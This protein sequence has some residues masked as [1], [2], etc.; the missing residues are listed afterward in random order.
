[1]LQISHLLC[2]A[3]TCSPS[4]SPALRYAVHLACSLGATLHLVP[5]G[6]PDRGAWTEALRAAAPDDGAALDLQIEAPIDDPDAPVPDLRAYEQAHDVDLVVTGTPAD[7]GSTSPGADPP[8]QALL[9]GLTSSVLVVGEHAPTPPRRILVPTDLSEAARYA[10]DYATT[11]AVPSDAPIDLLHVIE[12]VPYVA[13]TRMDRL[14]LSGPSFPERR[15]RRHL[16]AFLDTLPDA[17]SSITPHFEFGDPADQIVR[18]ANR[19]EVDLVVLSAR[20]GSAPS[21]S[22]LGPV[23]ERVLRRPPCPVLLARPTD[24][25][26]KS[27]PN[28]SPA[29]PM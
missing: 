19:H 15:A 25:D 12:A 6:E 21:H 11:V 9:Y 29:P 24:P 7:Q 20:G 10:L 23:A 8:T 1:M 18:F 16:D 2:L 27:P 5:V 28:G 26:D 3:P 13:L 14:S 22:S 17:P 4:T